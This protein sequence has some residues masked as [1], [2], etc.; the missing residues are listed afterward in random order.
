MI[1]YT[2]TSHN[3][4]R[5]VKNTTQLATWHHITLPLL[6]K[7]KTTCPQHTSFNP[8]RFQ[9]WNVSP[10]FTFHVSPRFTFH[11]SPRFTFHVQTGRSLHL[12]LA[13][14]GRSAV[15]R[16]R[17]PQNSS[18]TIQPDW[19]YITLPLA[20]INKIMSTVK[21]TTVFGCLPIWLKLWWWM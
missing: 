4:F 1:R 11:V 14:F 19:H 5:S 7:S 20:T 21:T 18:T 9:R 3:G 12:T 10:R 2:G 8:V 13:F 6:T 17:N 15:K 16:D